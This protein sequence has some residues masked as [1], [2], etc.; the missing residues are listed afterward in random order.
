MGAQM[1][2]CTSRPRDV[3]LMKL[4]N[5]DTPGNCQFLASI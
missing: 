3:K 1:L 4:T 5:G 2:S